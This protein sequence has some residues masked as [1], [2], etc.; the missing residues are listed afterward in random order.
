MGNA[1]LV[2]A[3]IVILGAI[4]IKSAQLLNNAAERLG[5][6]EEELNEKSELLQLLGKSEESY[7]QLADAMPQIVWTA[8]PD[9]FLDYYNQR[10]FD[11]TGA[12]TIKR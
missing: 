6:T 8:R 9:G 11:Y 2:I 1:M 4:I 7:R 12:S 10:W 5:Q 3:I